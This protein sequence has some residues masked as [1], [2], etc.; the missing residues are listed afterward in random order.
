MSLTSSQY[1]KV[2]THLNTTLLLSTNIV[3][4]AIRWKVRAAE[5]KKNKQTHTPPFS[6]CTS[7]QKGLWEKL[8]STF[9]FWRKKNNH[10]ISHCVSLVWPQAHMKFSA[11]F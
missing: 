11:V 9:K 10:Q 4:N 3:L 8:V 5:K 6:F 2:S 1:I 7:S